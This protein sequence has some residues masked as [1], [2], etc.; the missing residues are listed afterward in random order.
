[1]WSP[2]PPVNT[3]AVSGSCPNFCSSSASDSVPPLRGSMSSTT[4]PLGQGTSPMLE[5]GCSSH[6]AWICLVSVVAS[7]SPLRVRGCLPARPQCG[8]PQ[9]QTAPARMLWTGN[10]WNPRSARRTAARRFVVSMTLAGEVTGFSSP[11]PAPRT[12]PSSST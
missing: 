11:R 2:P 6:H 7:L 5:S 9:E 3:R 10:T 8:A 1:M 12:S 4:S